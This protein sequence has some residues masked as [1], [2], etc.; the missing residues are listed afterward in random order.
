MAGAARAP[1]DPGS[2]RYPSRNRCAD[3]FSTSLPLDFIIGRDILLAYRMNDVVMPPER[4]F[5]FQVVAEDLLGYKW[6][7]WV[8]EI[9]LSSDPNYLGYWEQRGYSQMGL[10]SQDMFSK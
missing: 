1:F 2:T 9:E 3:G 10:R 8:T 6:A 4:G 5:P 7:K